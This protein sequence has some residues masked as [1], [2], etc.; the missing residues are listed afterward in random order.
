[1]SDK[2]N[3]KLLDCTLRD[4][5]YVNDWKFGHDNIV[6][7]F[8]RLT[9]AQVDIIEIGFLD[10]RQPYDFDRSIMPDTESVKKT[11]GKLDKKNSI[12]VGMIDYGTCAIEN[13]CPC[14]ESFLDGI[15]V[16]FKKAVMYKAMAFCL[17]VKKLGYKVFA[18]AVS[19][20][21]YNNEEMLELLKI[22]NEL[23]PY[24]F[25]LVDTY[26][27]L[28]KQK[29][30]H[31]FDMANQYLKPK[32]G[33]GYHAHNNFQLAYANCVEVLEQLPE[34]RM[35]IIDGTLYGMGK[36]AGNAPLELLIMYMN[37]HMETHYKQEQILEAIET[38][39]LDIYRNIP[40]GYAFKFFLSASND[41]HPNY[42]TYLT[43]KKKLSVKSVNEI[44]GRLKGDKMLL[45]DQKYVEKIFL[46]YQSK[47]CVDVQA[48]HLLIEKFKGKEI[49]LLGPGNSVKN[50]KERIQKFIS[51]H[52]PITI[53]IN[54]L[55]QYAIDLL[56]IS[57]AKRHL[58]MSTKLSTEYSAL[59]IIATSNITDTGHA[60]DYIV[61]YCELL[62]ENAAM[63]D[64]PMIMLIKLLIKCG[65]KRVTLA[66]FDG[67][68]TAGGSDYV[69]P[70][71]EYSFTK[72]KALVINSDTILCLDRL[73]AKCEFEFLTK[74]YYNGTR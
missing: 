8:E 71:M 45:Y 3:V 26:G 23:E 43:D 72:E 48:L 55:P 38:S 49:L 39:I 10:E 25:S 56:F 40:W 68:T 16:I 7:I 53:P 61:N 1:M 59:N 6:N 14:E 54:F 32:I 35:V 5:G 44:L 18:Q 30:S 33:L 69:N 2:Y 21:S 36:G 52:K 42:V 29:L 28:H 67:Y 20:T 15:R 24:A 4:G 64:N 34:N 12:I 11:F 47:E 50:E 63:Q 57:N 74:S 65:V 73:S 9:T 62:D 13:I 60:F 31:Y 41:C 37:E 22:V 70:N 27:L 58:Q 46:D 17:E 19:I 51:R 66:G